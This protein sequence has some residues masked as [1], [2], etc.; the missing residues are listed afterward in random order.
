MTEE[1]KS[2]NQAIKENKIGKNEELFPIPLS[3]IYTTAVSK[4]NTVGKKFWVSQK[5]PVD[6]YNLESRMLWL[7][8]TVN[9]SNSDYE[10][11]LYLNGLILYIDRVFASFRAR[12]SMTARPRATA[13]GHKSYNRNPELPVNLIM[14]F[15]INVA[16]WNFFLKYRSENKE[17]I[18]FVHGLVNKAESPKI[19]TVFQSRYTF[20]NAKRISKW[21][22]I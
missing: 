2:V 21:L 9:R 6:K 22:G 7:T 3:R 5:L 12:S 17:T 8:R 11:N 19:K 13:M 4:A 14:D 16:F 10:L 20:S 15:T 1:M 18:A